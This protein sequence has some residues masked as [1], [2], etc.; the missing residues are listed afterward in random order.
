MNQRGTQCIEG[1]AASTSC[2]IKSRANSSFCMQVLTMYILSKSPCILSHH[3]IF[4]VNFILYL[5]QL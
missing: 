5:A 4:I 1:G 2:K 3:I